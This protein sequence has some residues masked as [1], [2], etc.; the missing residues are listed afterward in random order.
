MNVIALVDV[1]QAP[2]SADGTVTLPGASAA[3]DSGGTGVGEPEQDDRAGRRRLLARA[4]AGDR[5]ALEALWQAHRRWVAVVLLAHKPA[6]VDLD[7]LMQDVA[8]TL[9]TRLGDLRDDDGFRAWLRVVTVNAAR[10]A[11]RS[12][13]VRR[14]HRLSHDDGVAPGEV[15]SS[16]VADAT[17]LARRADGS[18]TSPRGEEG[19]RLLE[20]AGRLPPEYGEPLL[21]KS[22]HEMSYRQIATLLDLPETTIET[23]I[24]R[25]RRMLRE[26]ADSTDGRIAA[27][28]P[29]IAS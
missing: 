23:R 21:L 18:H 15:R 13:K 7:D 27:V 26:L 20:L 24:T 1:V 16:G 9:M 5:A 25:G 2:T 14:T 11:A 12:A 3:R 6:D 19:Q 17:T 4:R 29:R 22:L 8:I 10:A 28:V